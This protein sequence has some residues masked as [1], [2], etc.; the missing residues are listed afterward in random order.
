MG[1]IFFCV[2]YFPVTCGT[3]YEDELLYKLP[4]A[5]FFCDMAFPNRALF[6]I[7]PPQGGS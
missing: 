2:L 3:S 1:G 5:I 4:C 7:M 6:D